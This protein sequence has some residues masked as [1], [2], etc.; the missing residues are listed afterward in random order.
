[1]SQVCSVVPAKVVLMRLMRSLTGRRLVYLQENSQGEYLQ[2]NGQD[3]TV[4]VIQKM[5][6]LAQVVHKVGAVN[7]EEGEEAV[8]EVKSE[9]GIWK[10]SRNG[11]VEEEAEDVEVEAEEAV[12]EAN[13]RTRKR[14]RNYH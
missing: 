7:K 6:Y 3:Q 4:T 1:M 2:E 13:R 9:E 10:E 5:T 11:D 8:E 14:G 12:E